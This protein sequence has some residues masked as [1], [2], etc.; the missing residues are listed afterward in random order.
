MKEILLQKGKK[1]M[2]NNEDFEKLNKKIWCYTKTTTGE[3]YVRRSE[4]KNGKSK[5]IM[6]A[7]EILDL[8]DD[9][10][11]D[12]I[13]K[14]NNK[15][16]CQRENLIKCAKSEL[17]HTTRKI[18]EATSKYKGVFNDR[19]RWRA[20]IRVRYKR[21]YLGTHLTENN[22]GLAYNEAATKYFG[23]F[24]RLNIIE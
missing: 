8:I 15:L 2:V 6:M 23:K 18:K 11:F 13:Y 14:D 20:A 1:V 19:G 16:N 17:S 3:I 7:R 9:K 5:T 21:I 24:A 10:D 12:V 22:A 4:H